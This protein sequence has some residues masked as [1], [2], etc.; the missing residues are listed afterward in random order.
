MNRVIAAGLVL[1]RRIAQHKLGAQFLGDTG[2]DIVYCVFLADL[3]E[4]AAG[5]L[6]DLLE[7]L[8]AVGAVLLLGLG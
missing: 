5:L 4:T 6:G 2:V 1:R 7:N 8:L 3:E